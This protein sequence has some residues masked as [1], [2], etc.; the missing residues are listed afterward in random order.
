MHA[1]SA[2]SYTI[3]KVTNAI[4]I[5]LKSPNDGIFYIFTQST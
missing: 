3:V 2:T 1:D 5:V 4:G